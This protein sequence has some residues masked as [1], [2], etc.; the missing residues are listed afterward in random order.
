MSSGASLKFR[1][2]VFIPSGSDL[3]FHLFSQENTQ[4]WPHFGKK[5]KKYIC[6]L[7]IPSKTLE[8]CR[9]KSLNIPCALCAKL[10]ELLK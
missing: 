7:Q 2:M 3:I 6:C 4:F 10:T 1:K 8:V 5:K 9:K